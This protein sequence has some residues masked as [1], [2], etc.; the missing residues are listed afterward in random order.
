M[1]FVCFVSFNFA[2][3]VGKRAYFYVIVVFCTISFKIAFV[4]RQ[5]IV[6]EQWF[7]TVFLPRLP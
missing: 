7:L 4:T 2:I 1:H 6:L 5:E 3:K